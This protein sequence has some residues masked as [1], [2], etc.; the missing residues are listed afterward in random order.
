MRA[1]PE[2]A[3]RGDGGGMTAPATTT[4]LT[5]QDVCLLRR[6]VDQAWDNRTLEED[7]V[8]RLQDE[9]GRLFTTLL[10]R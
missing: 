5:L 8:Q 6:L 9:L 2:G 10:G 4:T 3:Q 1:V 7:E